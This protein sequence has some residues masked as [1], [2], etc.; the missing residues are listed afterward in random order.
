MGGLK[1]STT[2]QGLFR[3]RFHDDLKKRSMPHA[4]SSGRRR[5]DVPIDYCV[6]KNDQDPPKARSKSSI[7]VHRPRLRDTRGQAQRRL[8]PSHDVNRREA[9]ASWL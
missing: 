1:A 8:L 5:S 3:R 7:R 6:R 9:A 2:H 4:L